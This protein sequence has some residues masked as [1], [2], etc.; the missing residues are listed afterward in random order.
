MI[1]TNENST[2]AHLRVAEL[3][4]SSPI[5]LTHRVTCIVSGEPY[6]ILV[7]S[8]QVLDLSAYETDLLWSP[9]EHYSSSV[10]ADAA[11]E[12][13]RSTL[14]GPV[15]EHWER[16]GERVP[17][18]TADLVI[19]GA[20]ALLQRLLIEVDPLPESALDLL[21]YWMLIEECVEVDDTA[22]IIPENTLSVVAGP[23]VQQILLDHYGPESLV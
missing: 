19:E 8:D 18:E 15:L 10:V 1:P 4:A 9:P 11:W 5:V 17:R 21:G 3:I 16:R 13:G 7:Y 23:Q 2:A 20:L 22:Y 14:V 12:M 6:G